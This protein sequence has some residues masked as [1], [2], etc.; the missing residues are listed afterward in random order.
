MHD[1]VE[2]GIISASLDEFEIKETRRHRLHSDFALFP[3]RKQVLILTAL[4]LHGLCKMPAVDIYQ[5]N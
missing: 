3:C 4:K 2:Y 5:A 1:P